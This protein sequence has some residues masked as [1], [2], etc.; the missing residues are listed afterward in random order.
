M[1]MFLVFD[2]Q[3]SAVAA[4]SQ[5]SAAM[6]LPKSGSV[7]ARWNNSRQRLDEKWVL[8][9]PGNEWMETVSEP[10][11]VEAYEEGWFVVEGAQDSEDD[12][13]WRDFSG[14]GE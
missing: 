2:T 5:I 14:L 6:G 12:P 7:T 13:T 4:E 3:E 10:F 9:W 1:A 11:T 8:L